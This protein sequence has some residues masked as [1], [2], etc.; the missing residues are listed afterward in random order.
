[1]VAIAA[2]EVQDDIGAPGPGHASHQRKPV[3][4]QPLRVTMLLQKSG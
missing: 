1:M 4:K 2:T 3:F